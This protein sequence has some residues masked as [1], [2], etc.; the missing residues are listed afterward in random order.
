MTTINVRVVQPA[1]QRAS[2]LA[3]PLFQQALNATK[4]EIDGFLAA[5]VVDVAT[6][7]VIL[8]LCLRGVVYLVNLQ[9]PT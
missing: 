8:S 6:V 2:I 7:N 3:D 1:E 9:R 4:A 5:N